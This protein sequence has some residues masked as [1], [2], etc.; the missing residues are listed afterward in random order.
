M[1]LSVFIERAF[2]GLPWF[3]AGV[4]VTVATYRLRGYRVVVKRDDE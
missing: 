4:G 2:S 3:F 1:D